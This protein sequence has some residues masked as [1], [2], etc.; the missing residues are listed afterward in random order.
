[1]RRSLTT[2]QIDSLIRDTFL[3][4]GSFITYYKCPNSLEMK[5][6]MGTYFKKR[7]RITPPKH[8]KEPTSIEKG[9]DPLKP[10]NSRSPETETGKVWNCTL[11]ERHLETDD[12]GQRVHYSSSASARWS[13]SAFIASKAK[14]AFSYI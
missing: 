5:E 8:R 2:F 10:C 7:D 6:I 12:D 4:E 13:G 14:E 9:I 3:T 11:P 1:M